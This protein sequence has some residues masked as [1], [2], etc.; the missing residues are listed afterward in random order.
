M[1][2][3]KMDYY[4]ILYIDYQHFK[5]PMRQHVNLIKIQLFIIISF[6]YRMKI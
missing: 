2:K 5:F 6:Y 4:R 3:M 1:N